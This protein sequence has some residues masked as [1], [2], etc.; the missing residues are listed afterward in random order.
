MK[1]FKFG[2]AALITAAFIGPG[3]VTLCSIAGAQYG[4]VLLWTMVLSIII[5]IVLQNMAAKLGLI[6]QKGLASIIKESFNTPLFKFLAIILILSAIVIGNTA[7]EAGN[8]SGGALGL[9]AIFKVSTL[10]IFDYQIN[11]QSLIIGLIAFTLLYFGNHKILEKSL[12]GLVILMSLAFIITM[13]ITKPNIVQVF[14]GLFIPVFPRGSLLTVVGLIGTTVVPYNLFLHAALVKDKWHSADD[15]K[16]LKN[17]TYVAVVLGGFISMAIIITAASSGLN[18]IASATD[19]AKGLEPLFGSFATYILA[20]GLF[21]AGITSA[22]TAPL[23]AAFVFTN[24]FDWPS[25]LNSPR[26]RAVWMSILVIGVLFSSIGFKPIDIIKFA[27]VANG[28]LLPI[29]AAFIWWLSNKSS[30][31]GNYKNTKTQ[32]LVSAIIVLIVL[33]LSIK[34]LIQ[35][36]SNF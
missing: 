12:I 20:F 18:N 13:L 36:I 32:K 17:D 11:F 4:Y 34:S 15:L 24:C 2:P 8:I 19:L 14:K 33:F 7:Y 25:D 29:I 26:F 30:L 10:N 27:Q 9:S 6:T 3:T 21:A 1:V 16:F 22:I 5:T 28:I 35:I 23:A 31:L